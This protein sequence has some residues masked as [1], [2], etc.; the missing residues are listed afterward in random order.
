[1]LGG[2]PLLNGVAVAARAAATAEP[3][4]HGPPPDAALAEFLAATGGPLEEP[5]R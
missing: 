4:A 3:A 5:V 1:M 2:V